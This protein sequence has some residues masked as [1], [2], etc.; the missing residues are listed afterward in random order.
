MDKKAVVVVVVVV[1]LGGHRPTN[2]EHNNNM[3]ITVVINESIHIH[4]MVAPSYGGVSKKLLFC[5]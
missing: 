2:K 5:Y 3:G 1:V 4:P